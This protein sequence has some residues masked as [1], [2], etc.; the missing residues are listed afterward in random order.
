MINRIFGTVTGCRLNLRTSADSSASI[1]VSI[2]NETLL[3][4]TFI[5]V[6]KIED[7]F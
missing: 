4:I 2:P 3:V 1:L 5:G 7:D 6:S